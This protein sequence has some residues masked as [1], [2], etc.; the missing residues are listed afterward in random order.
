MPT[1]R[2]DDDDGLDDDG[3]R[4]HTGGSALR[5]AAIALLAT[6]LDFRTTHARLHARAHQRLA[7][8]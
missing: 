7:V 4:A 5:V 6:E 8:P 2:V 1:D 3:A